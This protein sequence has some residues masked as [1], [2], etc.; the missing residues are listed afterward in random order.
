M[1]ISDVSNYKRQYDVK[2][3]RLTNAKGTENIIL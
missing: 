3:N 2:T 1:S